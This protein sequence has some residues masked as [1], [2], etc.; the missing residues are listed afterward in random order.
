[1][2]DPPP[3]KGVL[4]RQVP[5]CAEGACWECGG[6]G[7]PLIS[8]PKPLKLNHAFKFHTSKYVQYFKLLILLQ[9][10]IKNANISSKETA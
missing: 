3:R 9:A 5:A 7:A 8:H 4:D 6:A 10:R 2:L 1:M